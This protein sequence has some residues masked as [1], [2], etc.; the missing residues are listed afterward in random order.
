MIRLLTASLALLALAAAPA[1]AASSPLAVAAASDLRNVLPKL[2]AAWET[3]GGPHVV[4]TFGSSGKL[5]AQIA[6]GA[7]FDAFFSADAGYARGLEDAGLAAPGTRVRYATGRLLLWAAPGLDPVQGFALLDDV[8]VK[9]VAIANPLHAPYGRAAEQAL[10]HM[11]AWDRLQP[12]LVRAEN[13]SQAAQQATA[14][15][16][17]AALLPRSFA[18]EPAL[19]GGKTWL[20]PGAW[21]QPLVQEALVLKRSHP[22]SGAREFL[23]FVVGPAGRRILAANGFE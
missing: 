23:A 17:Q 19:A 21:H 11:K 8:R 16:V 20:V 18:H 12:K 14:G 6:N 7:P 4:P 3:R 13:A 5:A 9:R 22:A 10:T 2:A 1:Q 15:A